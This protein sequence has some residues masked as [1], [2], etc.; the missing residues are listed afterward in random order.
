MD[1]ITPIHLHARAKTHTFP[2]ASTRPRSVLKVPRRYT[3]GAC[4]ASGLVSGKGRVL[5]RPGRAGVIMTGLR[6]PCNLRRRD[7]T[8]QLDHY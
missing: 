6:L 1:L 4:F 5:V 3:S 8:E 2:R 7:N